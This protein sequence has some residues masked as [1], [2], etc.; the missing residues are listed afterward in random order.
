MTTIMVKRVVNPGSRGGNFWIDKQ[1]NV[2]YG[3]KE[4][5]EYVAPTKPEQVKAK[6]IEL[7]LGV[8][9][10]EFWLNALPDMVEKAKGIA[11]EYNHEIGASGGSKVSVL[12][13]TFDIPR[14]VVRDLMNEGVKAGQDRLK[15]FVADR[16]KAHEETGYIKG[17]DAAVDA[18]AAVLDGAEF[19]M[20]KK[21]DEI[22]AEDVEDSD[23][24]KTAIDITDDEIKEVFGVDGVELTSKVI[25]DVYKWVRNFGIQNG[26]SDDVQDNLVNIG[27]MGAVKGMNAITLKGIKG[28]IKGNVTRDDAEKYMMVS[29]K[30]A[31][32][33]EARSY[34]REKKKTGDVLSFSQV[35]G[36]GERSVE[37]VVAAEDLSQQQKMRMGER[38][39][40]DVVAERSDRIAIYNAALKDVYEK[41]MEGGNRDRANVNLDIVLM[42]LKEPDM[43]WKEIADTINEKYPEYVAKQHKAGKMSKVN[44]ENTYSNKLMQMRRFI[45]NEHPE[46]AESFKEEMGWVDVRK[47]MEVGMDIDAGRWYRAVNL[48]KKMTGFP[49]NSEEF[50][51]LSQRIYRQSLPRIKMPE[52]IDGDNFLK[53]NLDVPD[54]RNMV[55]DAKVEGEAGEAVV[56]MGQEKVST[57]EPA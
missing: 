10:E 23:L 25:T 39:A 38:D 41:D 19:A 33:N 35:F 43:T 6:D 52:V 18:K 20:R 32:F 47:S 50:W 28:E 44:A 26:I 55:I 9:S 7:A 46:Y 1:G 57:L 54:V 3:E 34:M 56:D 22:E 36:E 27:M 45:E 17:G 14:G 42:R 11:K 5:A 16:Y 40:V 53:L 37:D 30:N 15:K 13:E 2:R 21:M 49:N 48:A 4:K 8:D 51:S 24:D 12:E 31:V 29:A